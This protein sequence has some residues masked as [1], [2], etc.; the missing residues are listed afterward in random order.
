MVA[1]KDIYKEKEVEDVEDEKEFKEIEVSEE[2]KVP[3]LADLAS[4]ESWVHLPP[5]LLNAGRIAHLEPETPENPPDGWDGEAELQRLKEVDPQV[6]QLRFSPLSDE[7][8]APL[9]QL[10]QKGDQQPYNL[11]SGEGTDSYATVV[12]KNTNWPGSVTVAHGGNYASV[13]VGFGV[14]AGGYAFSPVQP[15]DVMDD[16]V[17][18]LEQ[19]EPYPLEDPVEKPET[20]TDE[21]KEKEEEED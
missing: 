6:A 9:W 18:P 17:E 13:Y 20:D 21:P 2:A 11:L 14:K 8:E 5:Y 15:P 16:P 19:P 7:N 4:L 10:K 12:L 3:F 1:P